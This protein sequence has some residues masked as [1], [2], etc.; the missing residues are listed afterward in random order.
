MPVY[1][2]WCWRHCAGP[3][4]LLYLFFCSIADTTILSLH[5]TSIQTGSCSLNL[6]L[7]RTCYV[8][9][10]TLC[11]QWV[12]TQQC[13]Q[14]GLG[15]LAFK[16]ISHLMQMRSFWLGFLEVHSCRCFMKSYSVLLQSISSVTSSV[17][18]KVLCVL[19]PFFDWNLELVF[20]FFAYTQIITLCLWQLALQILPRR[21]T[22]ASVW[23]Y[24]WVATLTQ[25]STAGKNKNIYSRC[26]CVWE[27]FCIW[28]GI[29]CPYQDRNIWTKTKSFSK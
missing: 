15:K 10:T 20:F 6:R 26:V 24:C 19:S 5:P 18:S 14:V 7:I 12:R 22:S 17:Q 11:A 2:A 1:R 13:T 28:W 3:T 8:R 27:H 4:L 25:I 9:N 16:W 29:R 23:L 21:R